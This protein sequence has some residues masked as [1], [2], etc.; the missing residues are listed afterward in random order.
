MP[1]VVNDGLARKKKTVVE[2]GL[3]GPDAC[4]NVIEYSYTWYRRPRRVSVV[5]VLSQK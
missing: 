4:W 1:A 2:I 5:P 3:E